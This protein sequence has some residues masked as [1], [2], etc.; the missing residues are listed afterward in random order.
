MLSAHFP[1]EF[2]ISLILYIG[3]VAVVLGLVLGS[4]GNA[5]AWRIVHGE[6]IS[7]GRS[8]CPA[9]GH[10]LG[11]LDLFPLFSWLFLKGKC[12]Y[13]GKPIPKRYP[14]TEAIFGL[15][16]L[17]CLWRYGLSLPALRVALMG[18][19]LFVASL[20]DW[21]SM[22]LPDGLLIAAA[23]PALLRLAE[24][25]S[26]W[27]DMLLGALIVPGLLLLLVLLLEKLRGKEMMGGGDIKLL[28]VLGLHFGPRQLFLLLILACVLGIVFAVLAKRGRTAAFPFGPVLALAAW[29]TMLLGSSIVC[30]YLSLF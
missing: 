8:H 29:I 28:V 7:R 27:K 24:S 4:F 15:Y 3:F 19:F 11:V 10:V 25:L 2:P 9:C 13:C 18:F 21:E 30:W 20:V 1:P 14:L 6:K 5:W 23:V 16:L 22:I 17:C 26:L 12:R